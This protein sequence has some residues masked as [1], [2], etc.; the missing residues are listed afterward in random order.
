MVSIQLDA[1]PLLGFQHTNKEMNTLETEETFVLNPY[2]L[3]LP[4]WP[5]GYI[6]ILNLKL[7]SIGWQL[8]WLEWI[9]VQK[10]EVLRKTMAFTIYQLI[11]FWI[12]TLLIISENSRK[13]YV[14]DLA[15]DVHCNFPPE[16]L[17]NAVSSYEA[18]YWLERISYNFL[19]CYKCHVTK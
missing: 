11:Q 14:A 6:V 2:V 18:A 1:N 9:Y 12:A 17:M 7:W 3:D 16:A 5:I 8:W 4:K 15:N 10:P 19:I 13:L